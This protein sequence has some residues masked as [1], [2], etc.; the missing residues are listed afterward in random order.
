MIFL[1]VRP[2]CRQN[3]IQIRCRENQNQM[4]SK[5]DIRLPASVSAPAPELI[6]ISFPPSSCK[7]VWRITTED[8]TPAKNIWRRSEEHTSELQ[9]HVN[10]VCRLLLEKKK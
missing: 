3:P 9:S 2:S 6:A 1:P 4:P 5:K 10:L 7:V 8:T